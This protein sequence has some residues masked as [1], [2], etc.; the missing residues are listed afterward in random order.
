MKSDVNKTL[1]RIIKIAGTF[2]IVLLVVYGT[3]R[4][5]MVAFDFGYRVFT[6]PAMAEKP[7]TTV[8]VTIEE[9]MGAMEIADALFEKGLIRDVNLFWLQYQLSAYKGDILPG[10]Y[11]LNTSMTPKELMVEMAEVAAEAKDLDEESVQTVDD[12]QISDDS[13]AE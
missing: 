12:T 1:F 2:L 5:S 13:E 3:L 7:G 4:A 11:S 8:V 10:T 6:E 9:S